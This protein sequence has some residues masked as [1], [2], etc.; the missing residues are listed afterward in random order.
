[1]VCLLFCFSFSYK[2][3]SHGLLSLGSY[4]LSCYRSHFQKCG[5]MLGDN[6]RMTTEVAQHLITAAGCYYT[7]GTECLSASILNVTRAVSVMSCF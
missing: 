4:L 2:C 6:F 7:R 5:T 1:M 3:P